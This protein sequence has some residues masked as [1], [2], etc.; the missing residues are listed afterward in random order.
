MDRKHLI[1]ATAALSIAGLATAA[2]IIDE[3]FESYAD[4]T[5]MNAVWANGGTATLDTAFGNPGQSMF[6][7]GTAG[8][9]TGGN[10]NVFSFSTVNPSDANPLFLTGMIYDDGTSGNERVSIGLRDNAG[11]NLIEM[12][13][14]NQIANAFYCYRVILFDGSGANPSWVA[15]DNI[16]DDSGSAIGNSSV[17][18]WHTY[19]VTVGANSV[20]FTLDLN[21]DGNINATASVAAVA[22][23]G[24]FNA[25]RLGGPSDLSSAGGGAH[26]D[27]IL[28]ETVPEPGSLALLGLGGLAV[29]RRRRA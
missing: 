27:N 7:P 1:A 13:H 22:G 25:I 20:D 17:E 6:H 2:P 14:Y 28:L 5:A 16:V 8:S 26:F 19:T 15:F 18:G 29:L 24:G 21:S 12:G 3:D 10:T 4:T 9:F 11:S 23:A